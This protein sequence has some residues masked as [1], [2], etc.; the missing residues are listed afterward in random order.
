MRPLALVVGD[1]INDVVVRCTEPVAVDSDTPAVIV[2]RAGGSGA[3]QAAWLASRGT[4]VRFA[5][6]VGAADASV[7]REA[8]ARF[9]VD[10]RL[11]EDAGTP[12]GTIVVLVRAD[13][14]RTMFTDRGAN[15]ELAAA[16][17]PAELLTGAA[18][19]HVSGYAL[20]AAGPRQA[21]QELQAAARAAGVVVSVDP[22]S[23][24]FLSG[25][26]P[27]FLDWTGG[28]RICF[29]NL[30]EGRLLAGR[31][32]PDEIVDA[33]VEAYPVVALKLGPAGALIGSRDG[34]RVRVASAA[35]SVIDSTGAGDAFAAGF[36]DAWLAE[37][38]L[39]GCAQA[40][41]DLAAAALGRLGGRP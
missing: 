8:L 3:N 28:S 19:L 30:D 15:L 13:G 17:L 32:D 35:T 5:G 6:R 24:G 34:A 11:A 1:V 18:L 4:P 25:N 21:V 27:A 37:E 31:Q 23:A 22:A 7:H 39:S 14:G 10:A 12:T 36:L 2:R 38:E 9:G 16:D 20:F 41:V 26:V 33:L 40:A 29:P